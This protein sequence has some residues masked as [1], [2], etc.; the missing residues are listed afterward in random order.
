MKCRF[1]NASLAEPFLDLGMA[2]LA[3]AYLSKEEL[4]TKETFYPLQVHV[5][6]NCYLVQIPESEP[7]DVIFDDAYAYFSSYSEGWL[8]HCQAYVEKVIDRFSLHADSRVVEVAS[9]DG[10]LL[11]YFVEKNIPVLGIEP[12][13]SVADEAISAGIPTLKK[14]FGRSVAQE[15]ASEGRRADLLIGNNVLAHVPNINDFVSGL[16]TLLAKDGVLTMEFPHLLNLIEKKEFDTIYHEHFSYLSLHAVSNIFEHHN[17]QL[18]DVEELPT[19]GGSLRIYAHRAESTAHAVTPRVEAVLDEERNRGVTS[20]SMYDAFSSE[21]EAIKR[22]VLTFL[23]AAKEAGKHVVGYG[24]AAKGNTLLNYCG[25]RT[26][27]I[28]YVVDRS[29]HKQNKFLPGTHIPIFSPDRIF[30]TQPEYIVI[31]PW[32]LKSG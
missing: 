29:P 9:N 17:L 6:D 11:Q 13:A 10:Y 5:C 1:C 14:F 28:D 26:D 18:F 12:A 4:H 22:D 32:N 3:N 7:P 21:V 24:A 20:R 30:E 16:Q 19:H 2:P 8:R 25:I 15:L 27:L 31:L 23:I